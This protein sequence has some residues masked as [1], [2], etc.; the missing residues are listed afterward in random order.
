MELQ[1]RASSL[2]PVPTRAGCNS[3][4]K[5]AGASPPYVCAQQWLVEQSPY[6]C[7]HALGDEAVAAGLVEPTGAPPCRGCGCASPCSPLSACTQV[8][9]LPI[10]GVRLGADLPRRDLAAIPA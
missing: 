5:V 1:A 10:A 2:L 3:H 7:A 6:G 9:V 8:V 4:P